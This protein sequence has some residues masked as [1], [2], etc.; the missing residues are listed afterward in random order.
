MIAWED[1]F[2]SLANA[3]TGFAPAEEE[4]EVRLSYP[5]ISE[6][7]RFVNVHALLELEEE[8]W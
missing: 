5:L 7:V 2:P 3:I 4:R 1:V 8:G 6:V